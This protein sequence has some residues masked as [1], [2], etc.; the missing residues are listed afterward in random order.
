MAIV[1]GLKV[2]LSVT[3]VAMLNHSSIVGNETE[4][5]Q[6]GQCEPPDGQSA[7]IPEV[8]NT[9]LELN[10]DLMMIHRMDPLLGVNHYRACF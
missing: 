9:M 4:D 10:C 8:S 6:S 3:M 1:Y 5:T 2:N 7:T